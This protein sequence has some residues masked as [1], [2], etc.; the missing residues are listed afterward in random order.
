MATKQSGGRLK[1]LIIFFAIVL[2]AAGGI[3]Y[4]KRGSDDA[5]QYQ[6]DVGHAR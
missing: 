1:W 2:V 4:F 6:T 3:W 5:P